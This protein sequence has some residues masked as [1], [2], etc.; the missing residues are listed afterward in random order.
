[1]KDSIING[2]EQLDGCTMEYVASKAMAIS[3]FCSPRLPYFFF[4]HCIALHSRLWSLTLR[5]VVSIF[6]AKFYPIGLRQLFSPYTWAVDHLTK[7]R[8]NT[9]SDAIPSHR[10]ADSGTTCPMQTTH[11]VYSNVS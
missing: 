10:R 1:M 3:N 11:T 2:S 9:Q 8:H 6:L 5:S 4:L 7:F